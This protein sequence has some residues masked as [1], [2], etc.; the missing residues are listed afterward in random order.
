LTNQTLAKK[1]FS[2]RNAPFFYET[3]NCQKKMLIARALSLYGSQRV[4][5]Y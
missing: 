1:F 5:P 3:Q 4:E 2:C